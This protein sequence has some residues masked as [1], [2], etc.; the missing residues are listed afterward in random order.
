MSQ[1]TLE[2]AESTTTVIGAMPDSADNQENLTTP[3]EAPDLE[4]EIAIED[5]TPEE[6]RNKEAMPQEIVQNLEKDELDEYSK[7]KGK[8]LKKVWHDERRAKEAA[9]KERDAAAHFSKRLLEENKILKSHLTVGEQALIDNSKSNA[10][11]EVELAKK[12]FKEAYDSGDSEAVTAAQ[13][14]LVSAKI[15][16]SSAEAYVPQYSEEVLAQQ[17]Q[18]TQQAPQGE[19]SQKEPSSEDLAWQDR[20]KEWFGPNDAMTS[21]AFG[22]HTS[23]MKEHG[24]EY[25]GTPAYYEQIDNE[26]RLRYPDYFKDTEETSPSPKGN[27]SQSTVVSPVK[28]TTSP[29]RVVLSNSEVRLAQRLGLSPEQ[30]VREKMKL[31][32]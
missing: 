27:Q 31:E 2:E 18:A 9:F 20:N 30:Y 6:D 4:F 11:H 24:A 22:L 29:K 15:K 8:Q 12:S 23:L 7:E 3:E 19:S 5:D 32:A 25:A 16:L 28:R 21:L 17:E 14:A 13:E 10:E 26:M 1:T